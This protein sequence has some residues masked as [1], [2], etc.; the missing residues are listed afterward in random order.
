[1][2]ATLQLPVI[3]SGR[4]PRSRGLLRLAVGVSSLVPSIAAGHLVLWVMPQNLGVA[5]SDAWRSLGAPDAAAVLFYTGIAL[6]VVLASLTYGLT[7][8]PVTGQLA[9]WAAVKTCVLAFGWSAASVLL[10]WS[11]MESA[12]ESR[13]STGVELQGS[14]EVGLLV[15]AG[16]LAL[17]VGMVMATIDYGRPRT[18]LP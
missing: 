10:P 4:G 15:L 11:V 2:T 1:M 17:V 5:P 3:E 8:P 18:P 9:V 12:L 13:V 14:G 16:F 6:I 7:R